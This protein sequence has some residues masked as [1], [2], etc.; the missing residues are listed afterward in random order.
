MG[1]SGVWWGLSG[2]VWVVVVSPRQHGVEC[3][4]GDVF[5]SLVIFSIWSATTSSAFV[6]V[7]CSRLLEKGRGSVE[8]PML[9][10][11][12]RLVPGHC[13]PGRGRACGV[14]VAGLWALRALGLRPPSSVG[15]VGLQNRVP[16]TFVGLRNCPYYL[17]RWIPRRDQRPD[18]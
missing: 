11:G 10:L 5:P 1:L 2:A 16:Q 14:S 7:F 13:S 6:T 12:L 9:G 18:F 4:V 15:Q 8:P 17:N 3:V